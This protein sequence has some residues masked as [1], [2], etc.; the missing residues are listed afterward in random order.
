MKASNVSLAILSTVI[1]GEALWCL[2]IFNALR[3]DDNPTFYLQVISIFFEWTALI[4]FLVLVFIILLWRDKTQS[5]T[6]S[7]Q[8]TER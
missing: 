8:A 2:F 4:V 5:G 1:F 7:V 3:D 6:Q